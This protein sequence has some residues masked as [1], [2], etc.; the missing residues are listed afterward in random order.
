MRCDFL[1]NKMPDQTRAEARVKEGR[2]GRGRAKRV[3]LGRQGRVAVG[4]ESSKPG[5]LQALQREWKV[6]GG[7]GRRWCL[8]T[9]LRSQVAGVV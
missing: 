9:R 2:G 4:E 8:V 3:E 1:R 5:E 6:E 7:S